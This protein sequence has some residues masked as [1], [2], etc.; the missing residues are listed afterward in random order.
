M[1]HVL[2]ELGLVPVEF[3][4]PALPLPFPQVNGG[5]IEQ[6]AHLSADHVGELCVDVVKGPVWVQADDEHA[7]GPRLSTEQDW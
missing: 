2:E 5:V 7:G 1:S 4:Q 3:G 6:D